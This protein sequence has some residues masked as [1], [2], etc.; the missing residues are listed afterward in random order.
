MVPEAWKKRRVM[1]LQKGNKKLEI[2]WD[3]RNTAIMNIMAQVF[4]T[5]INK[6]LKQWEEKTKMFGGEQ[7]GFRRG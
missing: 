3:I 4:G 1:L 5:M 7:A 6:K 2:T